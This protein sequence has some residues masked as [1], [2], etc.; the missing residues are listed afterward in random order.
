MVNF[1][2]QFQWR[3]GQ[4]LQM[5]SHDLSFQYLVQPFVGFAE[6]WIEGEWFNSRIG[7]QVARDRKVIAQGTLIQEIWRNIWTTWEAVLLV[8]LWTDW[9][10]FLHCW[11]LHWLCQ[12]G[13]LCCWRTSSCPLHPPHHWGLLLQCGKPWIHNWEFGLQLVDD[14]RSLRTRSPIRIVTEL[15]KLLKA[16]LY[17]SS[18]W[19]ITHFSLNNVPS[20]SLRWLNIWSWSLSKWNVSECDEVQNTLI[21]S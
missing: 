19:R 12:S 15:V 9:D 20:Q 7:I 6:A 18:T 14:V 5:H 16:V 10:P 4:F 1:N 21:Q 11:E 13:L 3:N 2:G 17:I 8:D